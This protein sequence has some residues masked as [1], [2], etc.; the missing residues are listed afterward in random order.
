MSS[1][2]RIMYYGLKKAFPDLTVVSEERESQ[3][4]DVPMPVLDNKVSLPPPRPQRV[5]SVMR[6]IPACPAES[7]S[8]P[9][10]SRLSYPCQM[11]ETDPTTPYPANGNKNIY[12]PTL[13]TSPLP[14]FWLCS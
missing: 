13:L 3:D 7:R 5:I 2:V 4:P 12:H 6:V 11:S 14:F 8:L 10:P 9:S 1:L